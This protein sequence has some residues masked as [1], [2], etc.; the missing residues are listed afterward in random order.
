ME[1]PYSNAVGDGDGFVEARALEDADHG[2]EDFFLGDAHTGFD[3][4]KD[5]GREEVSF[6]ERAF[7]EG[8][9]AGQQ[10]GAFL[11][12]DFAVADRGFDLLAVD[13][14]AHLHGFIETV[15]DFE[16]LG[17]VDQTVDEFLCDGAA[18]R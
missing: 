4:G 2:A 5:G 12:R 8:P 3:F 1:R 16:L 7:G 17:A 18:G 14:R 9:A 15:T 10:L 13:L 6:G 11:L